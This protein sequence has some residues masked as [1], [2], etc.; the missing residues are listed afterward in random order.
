MEFFVILVLALVVL[1][2]TRMVS[3]ARKAGQM[4]RQFRK[5]TEGLPKSLEDLEK[6]GDEPSQAKKATPKKEDAPPDATPWQPPSV[7]QSEPNRPSS[8]G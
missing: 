6:L 7:K 1:G 5:M 3:T 8:G 2:P 4:T